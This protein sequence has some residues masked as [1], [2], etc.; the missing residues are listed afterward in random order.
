LA[1]G[2]VVVVAACSDG[3]DSS[4]TTTPAV[5][6]STSTT[7]E[8]ASPAEAATTTEATTTTST[9]PPVVLSADP[10]TL[11]VASGDPDPASVVLWTRLAPDPLNGGGMPDDDV[12]V[13]WEVSDSAEFATI[14]ARG[15]ETATVERGH[16]VHAIASLDQGSWFFR[17]RVGDYTSPVGTT[18]VAPD[19]GVKVAGATFAVANCQNYA[20]GQYAA[21]R[22][23]AEHAADFVVFLGDYIYDDAGFPGSEDPTARV[24]LGPE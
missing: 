11:G 14:V 5:S 3:G 4:S 13:T 1:A 6:T 9:L 21:H 16:T 18:R 22:D 2:A 8:G 17:F 24:H 12:E 20:N 7:T 23:L 19:T 15:V 10:F